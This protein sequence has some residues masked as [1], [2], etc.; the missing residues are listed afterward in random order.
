MNK[1]DIIV[2]KNNFKSLELEEG[3]IIITGVDSNKFMF[4][5]SMDSDDIARILSK[6]DDTDLEN[7]FSFLKKELKK[8][9]IDFSFKLK[10]RYE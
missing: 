7:I 1:F 5:D 3:S 8:Q 9:N 4:P 10:C 2:E 6:E